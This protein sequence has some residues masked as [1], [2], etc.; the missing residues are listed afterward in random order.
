MMPTPLVNSSLSID[1]DQMSYNVNSN[2]P[3]PFSFEKRS[4]PHD[5]PRDFN[6]NSSNEGLDDVLQMYWR[7]P[8]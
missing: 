8:E 6:K 7:K 3:I 1:E 5:L 4:M 2:G